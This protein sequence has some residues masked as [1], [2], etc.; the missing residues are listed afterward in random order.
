MALFYTNEERTYASTEFSEQQH[1]ERTE[2]T[3]FLPNASRCYPCTYEV[4]G[5]STMH[6][7]GAS[8]RRWRNGRGAETVRPYGVL[9]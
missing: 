2:G 9:Q 7:L 6:Y 4:F 1:D 3:G 5:L 8:L